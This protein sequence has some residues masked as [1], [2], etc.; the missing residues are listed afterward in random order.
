MSD[1]VMPQE[2]SG[3]PESKPEREMT[4]QDELAGLLI[5]VVKPGGVGVSSI[6]GLYALFFETNAA[7]AIA[8][9]L[10]GFTFSYLAKLGSQFIGAIRSGWSKQGRR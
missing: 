7:K 6:Y 8:S 10:I 4:L 2:S 9:A 1:A 5:K 3:L